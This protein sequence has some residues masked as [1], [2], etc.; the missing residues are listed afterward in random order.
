M[1]GAVGLEKTEVALTDGRNLSFEKIVEEHDQGKKNYCYTIK[2]NGDIGVE[3]I[4]NPRKTKK[5]AE[6]IKVILDNNEELICTPDHKFMLADGSYKEAQN[7]QKSD[8]LMPLYRQYSKL[9]KKITIEGYEMVFDP[10]EK[11]WIFTHLLSDKYNL[12]N[13]KYSAVSGYYRHHKDFNKLNNDPENIMRLS[14]MA[15]KFL[16]FYNSNEEYRKKNNELLDESQREYWNS[17]ENRKIQAE[18]VRNFFARIRR[19]REFSELA[20]AQWQNED[21]RKWRS[22][23]TKGQWTPEFRVKR[24][25]TYNETYREK[26]MRVLRDLYDHTGAISIEKYDEFRRK[27]NDKSLL[28]FDTILNRFF[29]GRKERLFDA[30]IHYN[31]KIIRIEKMSE[32][33]GVYDLEIPG[34]HN[35]AL[36]SGI[37]VHNSAE[38]GR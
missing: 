25:Y 20:Q 31:H 33:I 1:L 27:T 23:K 16:E 32:R 22:E 18:R 34:T 13:G 5:N 6:V 30:V 10:A 28:R 26:A 3:L 37:F 2:N 9:G 21:L 12:E 17:E 11:R 14:N 38:Q 36:A 8:S 4:R 15:E 24:K 35:F 7:L 29:E 19:V